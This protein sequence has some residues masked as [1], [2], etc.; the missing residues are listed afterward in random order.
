MGEDG[1]ISACTY[2]KGKE[3]LSKSMYVCVRLFEEEEDVKK[4]T[5]L[6]KGVVGVSFNYALK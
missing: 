5:K 4:S 6:C 2:S 1:G 3:N